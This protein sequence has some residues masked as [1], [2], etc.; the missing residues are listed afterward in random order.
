MAEMNT[1]LAFC[2]R[3]FLQSTRTMGINCVLALSTMESWEHAVRE[4]VKSRAS[5]EELSSTICPGIGA[6]NGGVPRSLGISER[7]RAKHI[8]T[9]RRSTSTARF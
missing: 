6:A 1:Q 3:L 5:C 2:L 9:R 7:T 8:G 4:N